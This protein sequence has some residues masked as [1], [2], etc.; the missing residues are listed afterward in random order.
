[1]KHNRFTLSLAVAAAASLLGLGTAFAGVSGPLNSV[2]AYGNISGV[3]NSGGNLTGG[4]GVKAS[5]LNSNGW[6]FTAG[7]HHDFGAPFASPYDTTGGG[8][9]GI[10]VKAGYLFQVVPDLVAGPYLGY[11]YT[12]FG[13]NFTKDATAANL[14]YDNNAIGGGLYAAYGMGYLTVSAN[15]GYLAG[16]DATDTLSADG[17]KLAVNGSKVSSNMLQFGL[18]AD[19]K[20]TGPWYALAGFKYDRYMNGSLHINT[21]QGDFG[22]GYSF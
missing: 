7:Y 1:M 10:N 15:V 16:I 19:Y 14:S 11:D 17:Q 13:V 22:I 5:Y 12:H 18:Q 4:V 20:I 8:T 2:A 9:S 6:L 3:T 21:L